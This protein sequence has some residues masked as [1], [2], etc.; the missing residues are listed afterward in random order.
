LNPSTDFC[1]LFASI[2][3]VLRRVSNRHRNEKV[4][5]EFQ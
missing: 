3:I 4:A 5:F 1:F 2:R